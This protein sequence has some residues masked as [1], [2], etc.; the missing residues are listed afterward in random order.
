MTG[1]PCT[2]T[3]SPRDRSP[4]PAATPATS[5]RRPRTP[6]RCLEER[7][8]HVS[9]RSLVWQR[10]S[11]FP[12]LADP[13]ATRAPHRPPVSRGSE[14]RQRLL[15]RS[16]SCTG[17]CDPPVTVTPRNHSTPRGR[18]PLIDCSV[19]IHRTGAMLG[20]SQVGSAR[21]RS[22]TCTRWSRGGGQAQ[23][24]P[25][26]RPQ[27]RGQKPGG[28]HAGGNLWAA[29]RPRPTNPVVSPSLGVR[30]LRAARSRGPLGWRAR[31][32]SSGPRPAAIPGPC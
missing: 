14:R 4:R 23:G 10:S 11:G 12:T 16:C 24:C 1:R 17:D 22:E 30:T 13:T 20:R 26:P 5:P 6:S 21:A 25:T 15:R 32:T 9:H 28:A 18:G 2:P 29:A 7:L 27:S 3:G 19:A 31:A 8:G